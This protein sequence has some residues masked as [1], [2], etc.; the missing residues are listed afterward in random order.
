M[1]FAADGALVEQREFPLGIKNIGAGGYRDAFRRMTDG[2]RERD[3]AAMPAILSGMVG[4]RHG[5]REAPYLACP[6]SVADLARH[7]VA[8]PEEPDV[9]I[10]PGMKMDGERP[11]VMRGEELQVLGLG[12]AGANHDLICIPGTHAKWIVAEGGV[13]R[14]F[15]TAMTGELYA[16][17]SEH[18]LLAPLMPRA[19]QRGSMREAAFDAGVQRSAKAHALPYALFELRAA[20]LLQ[21]VASDDLPDL[22]SGLLIGTEIRHVQALFGGKRNVGVLGATGVN[23][24]YLRALD[25]LGFNRTRLDVQTVTARGFVA[26]AR[27]AGFAAG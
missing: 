22:I 10:V 15:H 17:V 7:L 24:R 21:R 25:A 4:S 18:T 2:W 11:D 20:I 27:A 16:A 3:G 14:E 6:A 26:I 13:V 8:A 23:E 12:E 9:F 5:W 19:E 1:R